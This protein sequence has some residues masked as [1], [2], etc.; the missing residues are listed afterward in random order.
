MADA[1]DAF[2]AA[3]RGS[4]APWNCSTMP[5][6]WALDRG[7]PDFAA[8]WRMT[9]GMIECQSAAPDALDLVD[10][11]TRDIGDGLPTTEQPSRGDIGV[12]DTAI[13]FAGGIYTGQRW[14]IQ[15]QRALHFLGAETVTVLKAWHV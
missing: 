3:R 15:G 4:A 2:I 6:D 13:G 12:I 8:R 7:Y 5:A 11:W 9:V 14:L 10:L 1:L